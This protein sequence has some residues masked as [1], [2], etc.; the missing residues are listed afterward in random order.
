MGRSFRAK[1]TRHLQIL[2]VYFWE[3]GP[4]LF[5]IFSL[6][7]IFFL[8]VTIGTD[9]DYSLPCP[10]G[11]QRRIRIFIPSYL[12]P[13]RFVYMDPSCM[14]LFPHV[15][16]FIHTFSISRL[17]RSV[18]RG[19]NLTRLPPYPTYYMRG[20]APGTSPIASPIYFHPFRSC[21]R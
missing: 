8:P 20:D 5:S 19:L 9:R 6:L 11:F 7:Y 17:F 21:P 13:S 12:S 4:H 10:S 2:Y 1:S 14:R 3:L 15:V 16:L 18:R